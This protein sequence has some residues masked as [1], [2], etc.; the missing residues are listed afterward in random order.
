MLDD[1]TFQ[2]RLAR[3]ADAAQLAGLAEELGQALTAERF[4]Q[5]IAGYSKS[6]FVAEIDGKVVGYMVL[7]REHAPQA[8]HVH[9]PLQL[10]RIYVALGLQGKGVAAGLIEQAVA[11][12]LE[13]GFDSLWLGTGEDNVRAVAFYSKHG[14]TALGKAHLHGGHE[15]HEDLIMLWKAE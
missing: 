5:D 12:A 7:R 15:A 1:G 11:S 9:A 8:L 2:V 3:Q 4:M 13:W 10:W 6:F 14:F